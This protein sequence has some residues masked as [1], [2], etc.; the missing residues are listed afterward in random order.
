MIADIGA[1]EGNFALSVVE[2]AKYLYL[3]EGE[4][5]WVEA[6]QATFSPYADKVKIINR[7]ASNRSSDRYITLD[8]FFEKESRTKLNFLKMDVEGHEKNVLEGA[9]Q[10]IRN[11]DDLRMA[12]CTYHK[13]QDQS[14]LEQLVKSY[15][16]ECSFSEGWMLARELNHP[17]L[18]RGVLRAVKK[19]ADVAAEEH[20]K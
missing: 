4:P 5:E 18:R 6:L 15:G 10:T 2:A 17:M 11:A 12:V 19:K 20:G 3:F 7:Y 16:A 13:A 9:A 1:A 8:D 14:L